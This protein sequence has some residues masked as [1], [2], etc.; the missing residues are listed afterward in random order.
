MASSVRIGSGSAYWGDLLEP[1][2]KLAEHGKLDYIGFDHLAELTL[3]ILQR[4][5]AK[6]PDSGYIA[7][8][9][10]WTDAI[11]PI[12]RR[13]GT[14]MITNAGGA[15]PAAGAAKVVEIARKH[16]LQ[17]T[18]VGIVTGDDVMAAMNRLADNGYQF[19][20][21]D[22]GDTDY[23]A[24]RDKV[25]AANA[26]I[27]AD[28]M[29]EALAAGADVV[30]AGRVSDN[31]MY[32]APLMHEFGWTYDNPDLVGAAVTIGHLLECAALMTGSLSNFWNEGGDT[33]DIGFPFADVTPDGLATFSKLAGTGGLVTEFTLKEQL[34]YEIA[35]P[36]RY[37]MPDGV[38]DFTAPTFTQAGPDIVKA[39]GM[40]GTPRPDTLKVCVGYWDG[41]IGEGIAMFSWPDAYAKAKKGAEIVRERLNMFDIKPEDIT[42][43]F[44]GVNT[45]HGPTAPEPTHDLNEVGLR[46]AARC[47]TKEEADAVRREVLHLWTLGG[48][49]SAILAPGRPR[50]VIGLWPTLIPRDE[51]PVSVDVVEA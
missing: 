29:I 31:A 19:T 43:E 51:V 22:N 6:N 37:L 38:A 50:P 15:N 25:V 26:Y 21:L 2:V 44:L 7:D 9:E 11:L 41:W 27:G 13:N 3:A 28:G 39:S 33:W 35:D 30:V 47:R 23:A 45:L 5:K 12:A 18:K 32:V 4:Q 8:I 48:V 42:F 34:V 49:G 16:G 36:A 40:T 1:A 24:I 46:V 20:N 17:G 14:K 10:P